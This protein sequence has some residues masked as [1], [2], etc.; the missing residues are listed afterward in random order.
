MNNGDGFLHESISTAARSILVGS[1]SAKRVWWVPPIWFLNYLALFTSVSKTT[2]LPVARNKE[3]SVEIEQRV[4]LTFRVTT[5]R[6]ANKKRRIFDNLIDESNHLQIEKL[7]LYTHTHTHVRIYILFHESKMRKIY[8]RIS[9]L[10]RFRRLLVRR[11]ATTSRLIFHP[12]RT[13]KSSSRREIY[14]RPVGRA[15]NPRVHNG[16]VGW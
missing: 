12:R 11:R 15:M 9:K 4:S 6:F 10:K 2:A 16:H 3:S 1:H 8:G 5:F 13:L 7:N 14:L